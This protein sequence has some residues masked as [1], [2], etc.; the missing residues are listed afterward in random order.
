MF[1]KLGLGSLGL[2]HTKRVQLWDHRTPNPRAGGTHRA[3]RLAV[4][5]LARASSA[6]HAASISRFL[7]TASSQRAS[8]SFRLAAAL[9]CASLR[10]R[11]NASTAL[12]VSAAAST[13]LHAHAGSES[14]LALDPP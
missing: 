12:R 5:A 4:R 6:S 3:G 9:V 10:S 8:M 13:S 1:N 11:F 14:L 2:Q 7:A